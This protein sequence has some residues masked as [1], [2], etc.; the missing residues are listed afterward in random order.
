VCI[1]L[2]ATYKPIFGAKFGFL[3][4]TLIWE[5]N[6]YKEKIYRKYGGN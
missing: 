2:Q 6:E 5:N 3:T 1:V 4:I